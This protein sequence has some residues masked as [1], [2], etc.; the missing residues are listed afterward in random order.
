LRATQAETE[1]Y[2]NSVRLRTLAPTRR[3][4]ALQ[5]FRS[6]LTLTG[7]SRLFAI[8]LFLTGAF[9]FMFG[10]LGAIAFLTNR[11]CGSEFGYYG[12]GDRP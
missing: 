12:C 11:F 5:G 8:A 9:L 10:A 6:G 3:Y 2:F 1:M 4:R 7:R